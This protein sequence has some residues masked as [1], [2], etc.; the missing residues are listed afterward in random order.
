MEDLDT[1]TMQFSSSILEAATYPLG[2]YLARLA[3]AQSAKCARRLGH[4]QSD[5]LQPA[6]LESFAEIPASQTTAGGQQLNR[7][8]LGR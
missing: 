4:G 2:A 8:K 1:F 3:D 7:K 5:Q 6:T